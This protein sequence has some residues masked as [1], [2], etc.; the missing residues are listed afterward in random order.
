M[1][2]NIERELAGKEDEYA[3]LLKTEL[4]CIVE[5]LRQLGAKK[6][7][8]FGS[9]ARGRADLFTD[10]DLLVV[11]DSKL[12]FVERTAQL[13]GLLAPRVA[14]DILAYTPEEWEEMKTWPFIQNALSE[15]KVLHEETCD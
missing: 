3:A 9:Y 12:P 11:L 13:Y 8:L 2:D 7:I 14:A 15:G 10:L 6:V 1:N 4:A 5:K